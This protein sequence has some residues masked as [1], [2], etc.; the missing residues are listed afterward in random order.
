MKY[1]FW[2]P[3]ASG[4]PECTSGGNGVTIVPGIGRWVLLHVR[5]GAEPPKGAIPAADVVAALE[6]R[7]SQC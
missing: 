5:G 6:A 2:R 4:L 3:P 1:Y 7:E